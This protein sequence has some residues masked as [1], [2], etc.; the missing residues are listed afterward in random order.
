MSF[1]EQKLQA[2]GVGD[3]QHFSE[4]VYLTLVCF[5]TSSATDLLLISLMHEYLQPVPTG[6]HSSVQLMQTLARTN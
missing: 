3:G 4:L 5:S 2:E 6:F 1:N